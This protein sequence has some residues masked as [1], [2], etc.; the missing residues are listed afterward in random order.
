MK[1]LRLINDN[2]FEIL[3]ETNK[4]LISIRDYD[5]DSDVAINID[6]NNHPPLNIM[7][8]F[9]NPFDAIKLADDV[10]EILKMKARNMFETRIK[11]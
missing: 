3:D 7:L 4:L 1:K 8:E 10:C 5:V 2:K 6:K 9:D 11:E